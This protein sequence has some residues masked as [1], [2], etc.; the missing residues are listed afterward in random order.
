LK[1]GNYLVIASEAKQSIS[2]C[3]NNGL[4]RRF[5]P[6]NDGGVR[7]VGKAQARPPFELQSLERPRACG[8]LVMPS[9]PARE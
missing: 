7:P 1:Q 5:A 4:L 9:M 6:R 3:G 8:A 2:P